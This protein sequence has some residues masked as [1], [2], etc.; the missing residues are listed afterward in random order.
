MKNVFR[1]LAAVALCAGMASAN[2][3]SITLSPTG[4]VRIGVDNDGGKGGGQGR[5]TAP[6][7]LKKQ[8][9][10]SATDYAPGQ[11]KKDDVIVIKNQKPAKGGKGHKD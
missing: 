4:S 11:Q 6:G 8:Y 1:I 7:Q 2:A 9:G 10:G 3:Q 5:D